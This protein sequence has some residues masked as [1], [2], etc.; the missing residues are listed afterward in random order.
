MMEKLSWAFRSMLQRLGLLRATGLLL[1]VLA[2]FLLVQGR[3]IDG[4]RENL[5][6]APA[7]QPAV[8]KA[9]RDAAREG[10]ADF[11]SSD[12]PPLAVVKSLQELAER[13]GLYLERAE[14]KFDQAKSLDVYQIEFPLKGGYRDIRA[15]LHQALAAHPSLTLEN[16]HL[17]RQD[18]KAVNIDADV[19]FTLYLR[20]PGV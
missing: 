9:P 8:A 3:E 10:T 15:F 14:Y 16:V 4:E 1:V 11:P 17:S 20:R 6:A 2:A 18:V 5:Q 19:R 12:A 13:R 7:T